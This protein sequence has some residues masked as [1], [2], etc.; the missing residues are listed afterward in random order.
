MLRDSRRGLPR[1]PNGLGALK[2]KNNN[3]SSYQNCNKT[4]KQTNKTTTKLL[5]NSNNNS[6]ELQQLPVF[7]TQMPLQSS[8]TGDTTE[9]KPATDKR[10]IARVWEEKI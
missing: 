3:S 1:P 9:T 5:Y 8:S 7:S 2:I 4:N 10:W 6:K